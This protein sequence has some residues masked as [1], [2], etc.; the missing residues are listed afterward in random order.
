MAAS[1]HTAVRGRYGPF[2]AAGGVEEACCAAQA[3]ADVSFAIDHGL[4]SDEQM[5]VV[6]DTARKLSRGC[7]NPV[8]FAD[9]APGETIVDLGCGGGIDVVLAAHRVGPTGSVTG[10][11]MTPEMIERASQSVTEAGVSDYT[12]FV[13]ADITRTGLPD[14]SVDVVI[15]N[16]VINLS[17]EKD[18]VYAEIFRILRPG[19]RLAISDIALS[20]PI[21]RELA[22]RFQANWSGCM[23][24]AIPEA[25]YM[26]IIT[27]AGLSEPT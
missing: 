26:A 22:A 1:D 18:A 10:V 17:P 20:E 7:G 5:A 2:A 13:V 14:A 6:P 12:S 4:Y 8:S 15:S 24:G 27:G 9:L 21:D 11:D 23:G 3:P 16:C 25:D 19:G